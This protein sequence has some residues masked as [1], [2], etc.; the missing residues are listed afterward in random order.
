MNSAIHPKLL[1]RRAPRQLTRG[2]LDVIAQV[3]P[4]V[5]R[6][7]LYRD[8]GSIEQATMVLLYG[9]E[10]G[11]G[12]TASCE[13][14]QIIH[15]RPALSPAGA[16]ALIHGSGLIEEWQIEESPGSSRIRIRRRGGL[17]YEAA[18]TTA[19]AQQAGLIQ[20]GNTWEKYGQ[21]ILFWRAVGRVTRRLFG[22]VIGGMYNAVE[23]GAVVDADGNVVASTQSAESA[24]HG[25]SGLSPEE[26][27]RATP[28]IAPAAI[29][30]APDD[31][32][33]ALDALVDRFG[34]EAVLAACGGRIPATDAEIA[35]A[36]T[37]LGAGQQ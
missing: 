22:D 25:L 26:E 33:R 20:P 29:S 16:L 8:I 7:R 11:L 31:P 35:A 1:E 32:L 14:V 2:V 12:L 10:R 37:A 19:D 36:A 30:D 24:E 9:H 17:E 3:A 6:S 4:I 28:T 13:Y 18:F 34:A 5:Y 21:D 23:L 15:G 27:T